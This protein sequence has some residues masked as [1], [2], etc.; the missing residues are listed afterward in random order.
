MSTALEQIETPAGQ[1]APALTTPFLDGVLTG[2][3]ALFGMSSLL[4][5]RFAWGGQVAFNESE[6]IALALLVNAPHFMASYRVLYDGKASFREHPWATLGVPALLLGVLLACGL[7]AQPGPLLQKLVL[8]SS[9]YLAWHY[10]GQT[11]GMVA[12]FSHLAGVRY[13]QRERLCLRFGP[14]A[15]IGIHL[16][17]A[18]SGRLPP[19][20]WIDPATYIKAYSWAFGFVCALIVVSLLAGVWAFRSARRRGQP[21]P[22]RAVLP[23]ASLFVWYPFWFFVP[24]GFM[25]VQL[26]HALQY[27]AFPIRIE[28]NRYTAHAV[29]EGGQT[30]SA[31][32]RR[33][34]GGL[35]Y[36]VFVALGAV[37]LQ[38]PPLVT[39]AIG[40]G[41]WS[42]LEVRRLLLALTHC[43]GI[44]HYFVDGAIWHLRNEKV[45]GELFAHVTR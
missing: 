19:R 14:R 7:M 17:F 23:W 13:T 31:A 29:R 10:A 18:L 11:W 25:W 36:L 30:P 38:G 16:M 9:V 45:R 44:H 24:G 32:Q 41:W 27:L 5:Y 20:Q 2:G 21:V 28:V 6:W 35:A 15:L 1:G 3:L 43:V 33:L 34:H 26:A 8:V 12:S 40:E 37:I 39:H 42:S 4:V 22:I